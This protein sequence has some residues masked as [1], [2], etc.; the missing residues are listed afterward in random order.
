[1]ATF[2][3]IVNEVINEADIILEVLDAR[4]PQESRNPEIEHKVA[5]AGKQIIYVLNKCELMPKQHVESWKKKLRPSVFVSC[6]KH[7]GLTRLRERILRYAEERKVVV[8]VVG[9]PNTGKSSVIN[10]LKGKRAAQ[11]SSVSG[12]TKGIQLIRVDNRIRILDTPGVVPFKEKDEIKHALFGTKSMSQVKDPLGVAYVLLENQSESIKD[13]YQISGD[14]DELLEAL[15]RRWNML[16]KGGIPD[17]DRAARKLLDEWQKGLIFVPDTES[18][19]GSQPHESS[20]Q[21]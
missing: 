19:S 17:L 13:A 15:T 8:G 7:Y 18:Q 4:F 10:A 9:Y 1:M 12:Y 5:M 16:K 21:S 20:D 14:T 3:K 2:W 11:T 6:N